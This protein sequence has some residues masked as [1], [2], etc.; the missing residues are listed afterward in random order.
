MIGCKV[1][2]SC[3]A[4]QQQ[5]ATNLQASSACAFPAVSLLLFAACAPPVSVQMHYI[6]FNDVLLP[7]T[8]TYSS[9]KLAP[10]PA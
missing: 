8:V 3:T 7:P 10:C 1:M 2:P 5:C 9:C 6:V 4:E